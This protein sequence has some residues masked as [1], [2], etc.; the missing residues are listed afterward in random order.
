MVKQKRGINPINT[1][2][3][4]KQAVSQNIPEFGYH[5]GLLIDEMTAQDNL[6]ITKQGDSWYIVGLI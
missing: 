4:K 2:W 5:G 1:D 6:I 3:M